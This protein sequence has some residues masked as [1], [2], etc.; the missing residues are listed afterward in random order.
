MKRFDLKKLPLH[1]K[2]LAYFLVFGA[3]ILIVL[4]VF[5][6]FF[7]KPL[8]TMS[9][10]MSVEKGAT[11]IS[12]AVQHNKNVW[13]TI[14]SVALNYTLS[15]YLYD[16]GGGA[17]SFSR[18][19]SYENPAVKLNMEYPDVLKYYERTV[20]NGRKCSFVASNDVDDVVSKRVEILKKSGASIDSVDAK[21]HLTSVSENEDRK[22]VV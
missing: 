12:K 18:E 19:C 15:V 10:S 7:I 3:I 6:S 20:D 8:Y 1:I 4:W 14:D 21:V 11:S 13:A 5:Q 16:V 17:P 9:K 22:S 2:L